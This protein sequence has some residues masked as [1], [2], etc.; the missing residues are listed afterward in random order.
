M[1]VNGGL[2]NLEFNCWVKR[3]GATINASGAHD[4]ICN[5][6]GLKQSPKG[7]CASW[8]RRFMQLFSHVDLYSSNLTRLRQLSLLCRT[9][10]KLWQNLGKI[11]C[12]VFQSKGS[13]VSK[14]QWK[15]NTLF[16]IVIVTVGGVCMRYCRNIFLFNF[17]CFRKTAKS[18]YYF[19]HV[20]PS[21]RLHGTVRLPMDGF[22]RN[23]IYEDF[24]K[25]CRQNPIFMKIRQG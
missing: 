10:K 4:A 14:I 19:R 9:W 24:S 17:R 2:K 5:R 8:E 21:V 6:L 25:I 3:R 20:C 1:P 23:L 7:V 16:L 22:L 11:L 15:P 18:A 12:G 13:S